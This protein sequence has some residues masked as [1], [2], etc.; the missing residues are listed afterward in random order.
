M[1]ESRAIARLK[2]GDIAGLETLVRAYQLR[3]ARTAYLIVRDGGL[4]EDIVQ[5]AFVRV[6][7]H[8]DQFDASRPFGP[9]FLRIVANAAIKVAVDR[10]RT[11]SLET[12]TRDGTPLSDLLA[13]P[14]P[15]PQELAERAE[16]RQAIVA[17]IEKLGPAQRSAIVLRYYLGWSEAEMADQLAHPPG[18]VKSRLNAARERLRKLLRPLG[19]EEP[20]RGPEP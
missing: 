13:D 8:I 2:Q 17:A 10:E 14:S 3:A 5:A 7:E 20:S 12:E 1:D 9:W 6:F 4:A 15:S 18:T 19:L 11:V 16:T